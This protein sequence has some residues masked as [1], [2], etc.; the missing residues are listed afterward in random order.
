MIPIKTYGPFLAA[1]FLLITRSADAAPPP[2]GACANASVPAPIMAILELASGE[3]D[4]MEFV[5]I[6]VLAARAQPDHGA[7]IFAIARCLEPGADAALTAAAADFSRVRQNSVATASSEAASPDGT[8]QPDDAGFLSLGAWDGG[9]E[10]GL[11]LSSGNTREQAF[12][13]GLE[14][15]RV[16]SERWDHKLEFDMDYARHLGLTSKERYRGL[17]QLYYRGWDR[18]YLYSFIAGERDRFS[19]FDYRVTESFGAGYQI[20]DSPRQKW[21]LE[22]GPG[23]R[24]TK[25]STILLNGTTTIGGGFGNE[26][27][28]VLNSDYG[29]QLTE[30]LSFS[31]KTRL[32]VGEERTTVANETALKARFNGALSARLSLDVKYD[33]EVLAG[34][35][36][37][38][39]LTRATIVYDF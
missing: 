13:L 4:G 3:R 5:E 9:I 33:S 11:S 2:A 28:G 1:I 22:G 8:A 14:L 7:A 37:T 12:A 31:N 10:L 29:L 6:A 27:I 19:A 26:F 35:R 23:L 39:T 25:L 30:G 24:Q 18:R 34:T 32:F 36:K 17:Y 16:I 15:K 20:F 38:D 21:S